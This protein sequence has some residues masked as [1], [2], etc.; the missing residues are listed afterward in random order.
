M[1]DRRSAAGEWHFSEATSPQL[2]RP[3]P[4]VA[5]RNLSYLPDG[6][7][8]Q[9]LNL[10]LP[11]TPETAALIGHPVTTLAALLPGTGHPEA[12]VHVHGGAWRDP[13]LDARSIEPAVA[14]AFSEAPLPIR[15]VASLNYTLSEFPGHPGAPYDAV[16]DDHADP[17]RE[18]VHPRHVRD[19][20]AALDFLRSL[21]LSDGS[22]VLSGHSA[23][24]CLA[25]QAAFGAPALFG[26]PDLPEPPVPA[27]V[28]GLNGLY[29]L[30]GLVLGLGPSH[31]K[32]SQDYR[33]MLAT[34]F[35][36]DDRVW[37]AASPARFD[38]DT[39]ARRLQ[40]NRAP[41]LVLLDQSTR[42]QLVPVSQRERLE[43]N[44]SRVPGLRVVIGDRC[45]G[46]HAEPW[47]GGDMIW[48]SVRD[49]LRAL[50]D[51]AAEAGPGRTGN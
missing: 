39:M 23:G 21:G 3:T 1:N 29:D 43:A 30:P 34:A 33:S 6:H 48:N 38:P 25:F 49:A 28:I 17:A 51:T 18:A 35:G 27:A 41:R 44:L 31:E 13:F 7:R 40:A 20:Y 46:R 11:H 36:P 2:P 10:Y 24:A 8:L 19:V 47:Q 14:H 5:A 45:T 4:V 50:A 42:D 37:A 26:I 15:M 16:G 9:T 12:Q 22:Y 32:S